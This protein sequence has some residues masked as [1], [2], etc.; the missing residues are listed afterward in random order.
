MAN[1]YRKASNSEGCESAPGE[2][3]KVCESTGATVGDDQWD[4]GKHSVLSS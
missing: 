3:A 4:E 1:L 2:D